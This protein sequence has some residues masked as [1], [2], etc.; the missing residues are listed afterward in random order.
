MP[1]RNEKWRGKGDFTVTRDLRGR[2]VKWVRFIEPVTYST[3][4]KSIAMYGVARTSEGTMSRRIELTGGTG[5]DLY[6]A[7]AYL[8]KHPPIK[9]FEN[10]LT[11]DFLAN[12]SKYSTR[13]YWVDKKVES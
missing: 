3:Y 6:R 7:I 9:R 5:R 1:T 13:G 11:I 10:V 12:P 2:F 4:G 8:A